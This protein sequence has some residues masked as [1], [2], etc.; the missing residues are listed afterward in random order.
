MRVG[1]VGDA[2]E[3]VVESVGAEGAGVVN[4]VC[5]AE[6]AMSAGGGEG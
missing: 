1:E 4:M 3:V 5:H 6:P 2:G